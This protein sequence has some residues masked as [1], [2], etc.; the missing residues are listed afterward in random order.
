[1]EK[2]RPEVI[3]FHDLNLDG[4]DVSSIDT[5]ES[6]RDSV[7]A[8]NKQLDLWRS[9][10]TDAERGLKERQEIPSIF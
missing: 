10:L 6:A 1:M 3:G 9:V 5:L 7:W 8:L 2:A 4:L